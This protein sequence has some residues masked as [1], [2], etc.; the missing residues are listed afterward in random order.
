MFI[1]KNLLIN[2]SSSVLLSIKFDQTKQLLI[3]VTLSQVEFKPGYYYVLLGV[4][5]VSDN[6][7]FEWL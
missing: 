1:N 5:K 3:K 6:Q 7:S 2:S 4:N